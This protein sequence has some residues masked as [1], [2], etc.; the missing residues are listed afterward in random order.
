MDLS[1]YQRIGD[2]MA[3]IEKLGE[4]IAYSG[5]FGCSKKEQGQVLA[6]QCLVEGKPPL[7]L[8]KTY[9]LIEGKLSMKAD[10]MLAR[11]QMSGGKVQWIERT[12]DRVKA[13]FVHNGNEVSIEH[14]LDEH[15]ASGTALG[16]NGKLKDNWRK[17][18]RQMLTARVVS[19]GVRLL[20]PEINF[21]IYTPEEV[22]DFDAKA[23]PQQAQAAPQPDKPVIEVEVTTVETLAQKI[24]TIL[25][26]VEEK[27]NA[28]LESKNLLKQGQTFRDLSDT[29]MRR[30]VANP[31]ALLSK[32]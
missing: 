20:A 27:A 28:F 23:A 2:P 1:L 14:T 22:S 26:P 29:L 10:T 9:H 7:E 18:P 12:N 25:A 15:R 32:L 13:R 16:Q 21:G 17:F 3:A 11:F 4:I 30:I 24:E 31:E 6:M 5:L 8:A 19:E